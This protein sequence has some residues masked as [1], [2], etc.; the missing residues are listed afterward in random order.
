M[1]NKE[2]SSPYA[3]WV[4]QSAVK[5]RV[6]EHHLQQGELTS[7]TLRNC[8]AHPRKR[9]CTQRPAKRWKGKDQIKKRAEPDAKSVQVGS[10]QRNASEE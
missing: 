6:M 2:V 9:V 3:K 8:V 7:P 1:C 5:Q 4:T 10:I